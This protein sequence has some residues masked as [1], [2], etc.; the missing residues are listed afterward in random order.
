MNEVRAFP[1]RVHEKAKLSIKEFDD[2]LELKLVNKNT[3]EISERIYYKVDEGITAHEAMKIDAIIY[4]MHNEIK[5]N[6]WGYE[7][8]G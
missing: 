6:L 3:G 1:L 7:I 5:L 8:K 2:R 4:F